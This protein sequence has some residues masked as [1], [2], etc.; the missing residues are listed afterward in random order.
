MRSVER[1]LRLKELNLAVH[2]W[3]G[4]RHNNFSACINRHPILTIRRLQQAMD[5]TN[6]TIVVVLVTST[7]ATSNNQAMELSTIPEGATRMTSLA[8]LELR[9]QLETD[10]LTLSS[11]TTRHNTP[12]VKVRPSRW[13]QGTLRT[14][15]DMDEV[16]TPP[17]RIPGTISKWPAMVKPQ[18]LLPT[19]NSSNSSSSLLSKLITTEVEPEWL[20]TMD[21]EE[22]KRQTELN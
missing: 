11:P 15:L 2:Q 19:S 9:P 5:S 22:E 21:T 18:L 14:R 10:R 1:G 16:P 4:P 17:P 3:A 7:T 13:V 6:S 20:V 8:I 12:T